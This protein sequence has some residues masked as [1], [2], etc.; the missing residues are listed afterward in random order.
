MGRPSHPLRI[1]LALLTYYTNS[2]RNSR[3]NKINE[4]GLDT[5]R[6]DCAERSRQLCW[7]SSTM[8]LSAA[9]IISIPQA[10]KRT[11]NYMRSIN[12]TV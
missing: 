7:V 10:S 4:L 5:L 8:S 1:I 3:L 9:A 12:R 2:M 6:K 11:E